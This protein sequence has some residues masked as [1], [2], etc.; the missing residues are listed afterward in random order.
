MIIPTKIMPVHK[1]LIYK[2]ILL[3]GNDSKDFS[4]RGNYEIFTSIIEYIDVMT[5]LFSLGYIDGEQLEVKNNDSVS[6]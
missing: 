2:A 6:R 5:I 3:L 1:S 4:Y